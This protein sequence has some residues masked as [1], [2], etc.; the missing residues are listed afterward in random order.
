MRDCLREWPGGQVVGKLDER[1]C[2]R[3]IVLNIIHSQLLN[4]YVDLVFT[5]HP[6]IKNFP[7]RA[8]H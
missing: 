6:L 3:L 8:E 1:L 4:P 5:S 2:G 7:E